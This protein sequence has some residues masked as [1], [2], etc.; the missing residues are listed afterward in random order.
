MWRFL[1]LF[2]HKKQRNKQMQWNLL[3]LLTDWF[4]DWLPGREETEGDIGGGGGLG[5]GWRA[6][7]VFF[8][9]FMWGGGGAASICPALLTACL[10]SPSSRLQASFFLSKT[11]KYFLGAP[12][13]WVLVKP[14]VRG[15]SAAEGRAKALTHT[16]RRKTKKQAEE[17][18]SCRGWPLTSRC[19]PFSA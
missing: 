7:E 10:R 17:L 19:F 4:A 12:S 11:A 3:V 5:G 9:F 16:W 2:W 15:Q 14:G 13:G 6:E 1:K 18:V 8:F